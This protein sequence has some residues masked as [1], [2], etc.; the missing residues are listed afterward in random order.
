MLQLVVLLPSDSF[1]TF[2]LHR[3]EEDAE[4]LLSAWSA[5]WHPLLLAKAGAIPRWQP[6]SNPPQEPSGCLIV[7][8][9][10]C[11]PLLPEDWLARAEAAG[12]HVLRRLHHRNQLVAAA[13][14]RLGEDRAKIDP[15]LV[16]DFFALGF[17]HFQIEVLTRKLRYMSNIDESSLQT[18]ALAAADAAIKG[19]LTAA[20]EH[21]Q[22]AFDRLHD[23]R[24]YFYPTEARLL[25]LT[26][27][28]ESTMDASLR[29]ELTSGIPRN[30]LVSAA[31]IEA[32]ATREPSTLED[33]KKALADGKASLIG[34]EFVE[35]R[36]PLLDPEAILAHLR[37]GL[38]TYESLLGH[39]P[40]VFG[41]RQFGLTPVLPQILQRTGFTAALHCTLD[42]GRFPTGNQSRVQ[43]EGLDGTS[44][45]ALGCLPLDAG[46]AESFLRLPELLSNAMNLDNSSTV[47]FAHWPSRA[48]PW[49]DD[50]RRIAAYGSVLG[51]FRTVSDDFGQ[52]SYTGQQ[53]HYAPDEYRSPYLT[54]DVA[55][56]RRA[57][58]SRWAKYF[59]RRAMFQ[60][61]E[62]MR[63]LAAVCGSTPR[64]DDLA[65]DDLAIAIEQS[66]DADDPSQA[67]LDDR[68]AEQFTSTLVGFARSVTGKSSSAERGSLAVNPWNIQL[69]F[70]S[71]FGRGAEGEGNLL[72]S[73][74]GRGA[75]GEG[76]R[77]T[78][79]D[80]FSNSPAAQ[81]AVPHPS[82]ID[83]PSLGFTW[84]SPNTA[85]PPLPERKGWFGRR[86]RPTPP[87]AEE[88]LLRNE[89]FEVH[90]D[91][92]TGCIQAI[93]DY[94]SRDPRLAQQIALRLPRTRDPAA[95]E[96]Y[97][98]MAADEL[99]VVSSG[100]M[101]GE[102]RS[103]GRLMDRE[104]RRLAGFQQTTRAWRGSRVIEI[105]IE[106]D[107]QQEPSPN[108]WEAYYATRFAWKDAAAVLHRDVNMAAMP[109]ELQQFESPRYV[110][111]RR[112]KQ[113]TT[114]LTGG[115][116]YHRR[117]GRR[118]DTLLST[119][120]ETAR[121]FRL[122]I[123]IDLPNPTAAALAFL[124][125]PLVLADQP[126][127]PTPTG[128]LFHLDCPN[129][130][131]M[132][133]GPL[134]SNVADQNSPLPLGEGQ[135]V[136][137]IGSP[138]PL[139]EGQGV[140]AVGSYV[141]NP[142]D[143]SRELTAPGASG[144]RVR[145]LETDGRGVRLGLRCCRALSSARTFHPGEESP[146][147]LDVEDDQITIP[148]GPHQWVEVEG[149]FA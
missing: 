107:I 57:P 62:A 45:D 14:D 46:R 132:H 80:S 28:A 148:I 93:S 149:H 4:Q 137:A 27:V 67:V 41:R 95:E 75:G 12:A 120:G 94:Q 100:P 130:L 25:D 82:P 2:E 13:L 20:R 146:D 81:L 141:K 91:P 122:G 18:A 44:L 17:C 36:L 19:D 35:A 109:T 16:G 48:S 32:M 118:L 140:R 92:H 11:E 89:F 30:L 54:Q 71:P 5:L 106:L 33:L 96:N 50:L 40:T 129:V 79:S 69:P 8:P 101:L 139:G 55:A 116:P 124:V 143:N 43:W 136:R 145:L 102:I 7:L 133:W 83:V 128:W 34:G 76:G 134:W 15:D 123:G 78:V 73:T 117:F 64:E 97:S 105:E 144:F 1:E 138:L 52:H 10:C 63:T 29:S 90:F 88:N 68:L 119:R 59:R 23:A 21:L 112:G 103:R 9:E 125:P 74:F 84:A 42:D 111:I 51:T 65:S 98:I 38:A 58:I 77:N 147:E 53:A 39:R 60:G 99:A 104:G 22:T 26:L 72:P 47:M 85:E 108:P 3:K 24:E 37:R 142:N 49:Y 110:D 86:K 70:P 61:I 131:A 121:S 31:V 114:I 135:S 113:H 127:P 87:L 66:L 126:Q 56:G 115:L 6:A